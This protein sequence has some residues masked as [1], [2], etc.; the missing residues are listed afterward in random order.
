MPASPWPVILT[1]TLTLAVRPRS[2]ASTNLFGS[3]IWRELY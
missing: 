3:F 2:T 1:D